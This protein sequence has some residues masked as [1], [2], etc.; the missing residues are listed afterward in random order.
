MTDRNEEPIVPTTLAGLIEKTTYM[1]G[2]QKHP[3]CPPAI[4]PALQLKWGLM[5]LGEEKATEYLHWLRSRLD[6]HDG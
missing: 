1:S 4:D 2:E 5:L 6:N 3:C